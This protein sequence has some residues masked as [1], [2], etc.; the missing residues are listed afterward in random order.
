MYKF[1]RPGGNAYPNASLSGYLKL[2][3]NLNKNP[4]L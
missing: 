3:Q 1:V 2:G 4:N